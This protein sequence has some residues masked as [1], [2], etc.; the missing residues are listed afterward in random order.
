[1][2]LMALLAVGREGLETALFLWAAPGHRRRPPTRSSVPCSASPPRSSSACSSTRGAVRLNLARF[3]TW[4]GA[5]LIVVAAGVLAVR[6]ARPAGG[7]HPARASN[8]LA[9]DVSDQ[10]PPGSWYGTL[11]K[12]TSTSRRPRPWLEAVAW[13]A[14]VVPSR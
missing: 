10:I 1:M 11:L 2:V 5:L 7:G 3:F 14:Y 4:T 12:G 13:C 8:N 6:R 9:F